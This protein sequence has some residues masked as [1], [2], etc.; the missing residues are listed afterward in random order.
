MTV[1][2]FGDEK[3]GVGVSRNNATEQY[4]KWEGA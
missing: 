4:G 2:V 3:G 1:E